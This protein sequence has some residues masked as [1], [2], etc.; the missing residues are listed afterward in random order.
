MAMDD[1]KQ[2]IPSSLT[3]TRMPPQPAKRSS[4]K[5]DKPPSPTVEGACGEFRVF[6]DLS[7]VKD[8]FKPRPKKSVTLGMAQSIRVKVNKRKAG[9]GGFL[10]E[11][12]MT[13]DGDLT[14]LWIAAQHFCECRR[15]HAPEDSIENATA[16]ISW[17]AFDRLEAILEALR[18]GEVIGAT[19]SRVLSGLVELRLRGEKP[20]ASGDRNP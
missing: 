11:A 17:Q 13:F 19:R 3:S 20:P 8:L 7:K 2:G 16:R 5:P 4:K 1:L 12:I 9:L 18:T 10:E 6:G 15:S 14:A